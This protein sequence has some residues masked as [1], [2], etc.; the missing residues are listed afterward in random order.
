MNKIFLMGIALVAAISISSCK[1]SSET[2]WRKAY[3]KA[4]VQELYAQDDS[5]PVEVSPVVSTEETQSYTSIRQRKNSSS[6]TTTTKPATKTST[7]ENVGIR[8]ERL[9]AVNGADIKTF[10]VVAGSFK[11]QDN[12]NKRCK[13]LADKG[14]KAQVAKNPDSGMFRV[15]ASSHDSKDAAISSR[16]KLRNSYP[17]AWLLYKTN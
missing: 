3:E 14:Y 17:D 10:N 2:E 4:R 8:Q 7:S 12:A 16:D 11:S 1:S 15:I 13:E 9:E 5:D 6:S